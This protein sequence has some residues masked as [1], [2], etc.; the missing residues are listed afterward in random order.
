MSQKDL[1]YEIITTRYPRP[2]NVK[3]DEYFSKFG[4]SKKSV[5]FLINELTRI[6]NHPLSWEGYNVPESIL[7]HTDLFQKESLKAIEVSEK[8]ALYSPEKVSEF[9]LKNHLI[10][11][12]ATRKW[13]VANAGLCFELFTISEEKVEKNFLSDLEKRGVKIGD[14]VLHIHIISNGEREDLMKLGFPVPFKHWDKSYYTQMLKLAN[15]ILQS[16]PKSLGLF[17]EDSWVFDPFIH[18]IASDGKPYV[19]FNFLADDNLVGERFFVAEPKPDN[20]YCK[21]FDFALRSPRRLDFYNSGEFTPKTYGIF[22]AKEKLK[23]NIEKGL[24]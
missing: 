21:Q 15:Q 13:L 3:L 8:E 12:Y 6:I 20:D 24:I 11:K 19:S 18:G 1:A 14:Q 17:C 16:N 7:N 22:Y 23:E 2:K 9:F 10:F 4:T 5:D